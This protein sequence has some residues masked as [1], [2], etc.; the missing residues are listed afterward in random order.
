LRC[1]VPAPSAIIITFIRAI[2]LMQ[3]PEFC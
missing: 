2:L 1:K 3:A